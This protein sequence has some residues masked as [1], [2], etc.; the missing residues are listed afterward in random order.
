MALPT[1][2]PHLRPFEASTSTRAVELVQPL[3]AFGRLVIQP[4]WRPLEAPFLKSLESNAAGKSSMILHD[5]NDISRNGLA[6][7]SFQCHDA[8]FDSQR[9]LFETRFGAKT[10]ANLVDKW[11]TANRRCCQWRTTMSL[12]PAMRNRLQML[13]NV[14]ECCWNYWMWYVCHCWF[15]N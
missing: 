10:A 1:N 11:E 9:L 13:V 12:Q 7:S 6:S 8:M 4:A 5:A 15:C 3:E 14:C 2:L